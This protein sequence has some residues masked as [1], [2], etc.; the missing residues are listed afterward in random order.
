MTFSDAISKRLYELCSERHITPN[1]LAT[2]SGIRQSTLEDII[3]GRTKNPGLRTL[4]RIAV[5]LNITLA[6]LLDFPLMNETQ[7]DDE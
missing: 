4:H 5:G 2:L 1:K 6:Q 3:L 7:F